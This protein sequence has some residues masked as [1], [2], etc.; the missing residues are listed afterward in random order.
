MLCQVT[1]SSVRLVSSTTRELRYEWNA[2]S[3]YSINV[4]TANASQV[5]FIFANSIKLFLFLFECILVDTKYCSNKVLSV[6]VYALHFGCL[7][8][9]K[10][11]IKIY[12]MENQTEYGFPW[13]ILN[14]QRVFK[15]WK[16][17]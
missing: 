1:S 14:N 5:C 10:I 7:L 6:P 2:P 9:E 13:R 15:P 12:K 17:F 16:M 3:G 11:I 8:K 4:A